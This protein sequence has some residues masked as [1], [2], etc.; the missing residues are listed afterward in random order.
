MPDT[1]P[2]KREE[3]DRFLEDVGA[4]VVPRGVSG[5]FDEQGKRRVDPFRG[6]R[7]RITRARSGPASPSAPSTR[8]GTF[9]GRDQVRRAERE[10]PEAEAITADA[11]GS[12]TA[13]PEHPA[14]AAYRACH[15][16]GMSDASIAQVMGVSLRQV[17]RMLD[18][19]GLES[20]NAYSFRSFSQ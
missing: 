15:A 20:R 10:E 4:M 1:I 18:A 3:I 13:R 19:L 5:I 6:S 16:A 12:T 11:P 8:R 9:E 2:V 7:A 14:R 17:R